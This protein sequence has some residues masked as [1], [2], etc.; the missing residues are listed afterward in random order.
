MLGNYWRTVAGVLSATAVAQAIPIWGSLFIAR[1][2]VP[3]QLGAYSAWLGMVY[4]AAVIVTARLEMTQARHLPIS[5]LADAHVCAAFR[6]QPTQISLKEAVIAI[7]VG[8]PIPLNRQP[9]YQ[10]L[11][12]AECTPSWT[13]FPNRKRACPCTRY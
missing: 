5:Y 1:L 3:E 13:N 6:C 10:H 9:V 12:C 7:S 8:C 4:L 2:Y 11:C